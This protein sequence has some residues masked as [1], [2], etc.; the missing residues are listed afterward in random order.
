[1]L[2]HPAQ[3]S[4][5]LTLVLRNLYKTEQAAHTV[6]T[7]GKPPDNLEE[8]FSRLAFAFMQPRA[9]Q[10]ILTD[11]LENNGRLF[12]P[13]NQKGI[14]ESCEKEVRKNITYFTVLEEVQNMREFYR[15]QFKH[16]PMKLAAHLGQGCFTHD[17][18]E[19]LL[20]NTPPMET[21]LYD[22]V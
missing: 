17:F 18:L 5:Y 3:G 16:Q 6:V 4:Y 10:R 8:L 11:V 12:D 13:I 9:C 19:V 1:M 2:Y 21:M 15:E 7:Q 22:V 20:T 14:S